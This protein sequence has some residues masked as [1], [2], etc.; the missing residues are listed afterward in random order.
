MCLTLFP[1]YKLTDLPFF[2]RNSFHEC[3]PENCAF[4]AAG[5]ACGNRPFAEYVPCLDDFQTKQIEHQGL[6]LFST[7]SYSPDELIIEYCGEIIPAHPA[8]AGLRDSRS[9]F[10]LK[11]VDGYKLDITTR[12]SAAR[13]I[14]HSCHPNA[15]LQLWH[16]NGA[17]RLGVFAAKAITSDVQITCDY[18]AGGFFNYG[19]R[20]K[21]PCSCGSF[22]CAGFIDTGI[23][24]QPVLARKRVI[25]DDEDEDEK[26][27]TPLS[28]RQ[29]QITILKYRQSSTTPKHADSQISKPELEKRL[30]PGDNSYETDT[31]NNAWRADE[32]TVADINSTEFPKMAQQDSIVI[33]KGDSI[34]S[35]K[36]LVDDNSDGSVEIA[37]V[38]RRSASKKRKIEL[39]TVE[40]DDIEAHPKSPVDLHNAGGNSSRPFSR[41]ASFIVPI[42]RSSSQT[43]LS[44]QSILNKTP[45]P[46]T[47]AVARHENS[48]TATPLGLGLHHS[49]HRFD[50][51]TGSSPRDMSINSILSG[52]SEENDEIV[53]DP[54]KTSTSALTLDHEKEKRYKFPGYED[55]TIVP[56]PH[57]P[58]YHRASSFF[59]PVNG[60]TLH[61]PYFGSPSQSIASD[62]CNNLPKLHNGTSWNNGSGIA[63]TLKAAAAVS[64]KLELTKATPR[65]F[66]SVSYT[67]LPVTYEGSE[68]HPAATVAATGPKAKTTCNGTSVTTI[69]GDDDASAGNTPVAD[70][71][72]VTSHPVSD[73]S[74]GWEKL[75]INNLLS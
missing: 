72:A 43:S 15:R 36:T 12:A 62:S 27:A 38:V 67:H 28:H 21:L 5:N 42:S 75:S 60:G 53:M 10:T 48:V 37:R 22:N 7:R 51:E 71:S 57:L 66:S 31:A 69:V 25:V 56:P 30:N 2:L 58:V 59:D 74:T 33:T 20:R 45:P 9:E 29:S 16:V 41:N 17:P 26:P 61:L 13:F 49:H 70:A 32:A 8:S 24:S 47:A 34:I 46:T 14:N 55:D 68:K 18:N 11:F 52:Y 40:T 63:E 1:I 6:G 3:S 23:K 54:S 50:T 64:P 4:T 39:S 44:L 73:P 35:S 19:T 65:P